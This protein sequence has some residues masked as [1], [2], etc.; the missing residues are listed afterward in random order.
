MM[1]QYG[2]RYA[3]GESPRASLDEIN[4]VTI[5]AIDDEAPEIG[6]TQVRV[7]SRVCYLIRSTRSSRGKRMQ[8]LLQ[9]DDDIKL[10]RLIASSRM[11]WVL[12]CMASRVTC[13]WRDIV[14]PPRLAFVEPV[15][16]AAPFR[17]LEAPLARPV[18][19][20]RP[21]FLAGGLSIHLSSLT[22]AAAPDGRI[23][24][25]LG[26]DAEPKPTP[27][28]CAASMLPL[29]RLSRSGSWL[30]AM[31]VRSLLPAGLLARDWAGHGQPWRVWCSWYGLIPG[32]VKII[33]GVLSG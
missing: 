18:A 27:R 10:C 24:G 16:L 15:V 23:L 19:A 32:S 5:R 13:L 14:L 22:A 11:R 30:S 3:A 20:D 12:C 29:R 21:S 8:I 25:A 7:L 28:R 33:F 2:K 26:L 4:Q 17:R 6:Q 31:S 1:D 9:L